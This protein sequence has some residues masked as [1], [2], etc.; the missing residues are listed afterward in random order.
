MKVHWCILDH[1][2]GYFLKTQHHQLVIQPG[3][4][5][6]NLW[7]DTGWGGDFKQ[8]QTCFMLKL[9][10]APILWSSKR[11][12]VVALSTCTAEYVALSDST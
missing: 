2:V 5:S 7:S 6:L 3:K 10:D 8:S 4:V 9:G 1:V 11:K 12:G